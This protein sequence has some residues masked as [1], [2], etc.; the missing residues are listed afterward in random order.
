MERWQRARRAVA[1]VSAVV[2]IAAFVLYR[3]GVG[4]TPMSSSKSTFIFVG[5]GVKPSADPPKP[6]EP[7]AAG[8]QKAPAKPGE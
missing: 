5:P 7:P 4:A 6:A 2:L 3:A 8:E 1:L